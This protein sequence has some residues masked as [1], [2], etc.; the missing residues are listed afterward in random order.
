MKKLLLLFGV[1]S[2]ASC[3]LSGDCIKSAGTVTT[4]IVDVTAFEN[5]Y[6]NPG[7]ALVITQGDE[8]EVTIEAGDNFI[9]EIQVSQNGNALTLKD[10]SGCNWVRDYGQ[11]TVYVTAPNLVEIYS[12]TERT[13]SSN[14]VLTYPLLRLYAL[15]FY[16]GVGTGNFIME[17]DNNQLVAQS[18]HVATFFISGQTNQLLL[19]FYNGNGRF[20]GENLVA[21]EI[22]VFHRGA[23]DMIVN[24]VNALRGDIYS[25]GDLISKTHPAIVEVIEHYTGNLIFD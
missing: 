21:D 16:G 11:T 19:N 7:I 20:E 9:D 12:N 23:N 4:K 17:I 5:I 3:G 24:P 18:S 13:I 2:F 6:V 8:Y 10:E 14:G 25:T 1:F 15:E 22:I